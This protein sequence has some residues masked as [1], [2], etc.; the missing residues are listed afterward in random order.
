MTIRLS[1]MWN[2][3]QI[4]LVFFDAQVNVSLSNVVY[5]PVWEIYSLKSNSWR[6]LDLDMTTFYRSLVGVPEQVYMNG[7]CHWLGES[8]TYINNVYL[9]SFDLGSEEFVL[10]SILSNV[11]NDINFELVDT[12]LILLNESIALI[13]NDAQMTTFHISI[14]GE[15]G[16]KESWIKLFIVGPLPCLGHPIGVGKNGEIFIAKEDKK[17]ARCDLS[18]H[19]IQE[20]G[21]KGVFHRCQMVIYKKSLHSF[22]E[23]PSFNLR[24]LFCSCLGL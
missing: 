15:I 9:V 14:L 2:F 20:L 16:A 7:V 10:T 13:S 3:I 19:T 6:K 12:H 5:D 1:D 8:E 18:T 23:K 17:L 11:D 22:S 4:Y 21:I 24:K